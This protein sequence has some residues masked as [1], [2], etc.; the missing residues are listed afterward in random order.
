[1]HRARG[2]SCFLVW[3]RLMGTHVGGDCFNGLTSL[4]R[5]FR[6]RGPPKGRLCK[7]AAALRLLNKAMSQ[8]K[9][10]A[11]L[12]T[13][14]RSARVENPGRPVRQKTVATSESHSPFRA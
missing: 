7:F 13:A 9:S 12:A 5:A 1:M 8:L 6:C 14:P 11:G 2:F 10:D 4:G 3:H